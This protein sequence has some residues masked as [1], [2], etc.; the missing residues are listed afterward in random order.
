MTK[1][2][3]LPATKSRGRRVREITPQPAR[4]SRRF[5]RFIVRNS[6]ALAGFLAAVHLLLTLLTFLPQPHTGGDNAAYITLAR[7][8]L[9]RQAYLS[10]YDPA[11]PPH[12]QYPPVFPG[13]LAFGM[14]IGLRPFAGLKIL[15]SLMSA[16]AVTLSF[17]WILRRRRPVL[18]LA[19]GAILAL[20]PGVLELAHWVLSDVPFWFFTMLAL[21]GFERARPDQRAHWGAAIAATVL[22]YFTRSAGLP[23]LLGAFVWLIWRRNWRP[24]AILAGIAVPL[25]FLWWLRAQGQG[26]VDYVSQFWF[27]NPYEPALGRIGVSDLFTRA[28]E[29]ANKYVRIHLPML[30]IARTNALALLLALGVTGLALVGWVRRLRRPALAEI[31]LP[32]YVGLLLIWPAVWSGERFLLPALPVLLYF[33]GDALARVASRV[34]RGSAFRVGVAATAVLIVA[35]MPAQVTAIRAS[36]ECTLE[37]RAGERFP[38]LPPAWRDWFGVAEWARTSLPDDAVVL[39]RKPRLFYVLGDRP[40]TYYPMSDQPGELLRVAGEAGARYIVFDHL[41]GLSQRYLVPAVLGR[42]RA[43]CLVYD[44]PFDHTLVLGIL[45]GAMAMTDQPVDPATATLSE[46]PAAYLSPDALRRRQLSR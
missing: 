22:A 1:L 3:R 9:E 30:L 45:P 18:A 20:S 32:L 34:R 23:L 43:F 46:C 38:C 36:S 8:L 27:V 21:W 4:R 29:N 16:A 7:S 28:I 15:I 6:L 35:M 42:V 5:A 19:A 11:A 44:S 10:L 39:S 12:T 26:G 13:L 31:F 17:L 24:L 40:G 33:A 37:F 25:A 14:M 2:T 41:D